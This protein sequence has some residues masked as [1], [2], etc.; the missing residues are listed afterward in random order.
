[1]ASYK[2]SMRSAGISKLYS[3]VRIEAEWHFV[4][5]LRL[6]KGLKCKTKCLTH[7]REHIIVSSLREDCRAWFLS[8]SPS[9]RLPLTSR[10]S[11]W[12]VIPSYMNT[13]SHS[14]LLLIL[15][16]PEI[17][18]VPSKNLRCFLRIANYSDVLNVIIIS[19]EKPLKKL[20][21]W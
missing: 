17:F 1:M 6:G 8:S 19:T 12:V 2:L 14:R 11:T 10:G 5:Y 7:I 15:N 16:S 4:T 18:K 21:R 3:N 13:H 9:Y 20:A